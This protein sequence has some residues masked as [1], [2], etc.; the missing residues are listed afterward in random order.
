MPKLNC[1]N[2]VW[3]QLAGP[4]HT[5]DQLFGLLLPAPIPVPQ[6]G[7]TGR[8]LR[9]SHLFADTDA[10]AGPTCVASAQHLAH[11]ALA[12]EVAAFCPRL[13][14]TIWDSAAVVVLVDQQTPNVPA[15]PPTTL[16]DRYRQLTGAV[17]YGTFR[18]NFHR[19]D[20]IELDLRGHTHVRGA[21]FSCSRLKLANMVLI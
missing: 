8:G 5:F 2:P 6:L 1:P 9:A 15:D 3:G 10:G 17:Q 18:P 20:R 14:C 12:A 7:Q 4:R 11:L 19:F 21:A 16:L 13:G